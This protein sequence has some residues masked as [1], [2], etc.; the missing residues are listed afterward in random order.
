MGVQAVGLLEELG[1]PPGVAV[2]D[3]GSREG[4]EGE[5]LG[6]EVALVARLAEHGVEVLDG[7]L[8]YA[9]TA[10]FTVLITLAVTRAI[11]PRWMTYLGYASAAL[12]ATGVVIPLGVHAATLTN[13]AGY[14]A[15]CLWLIAM[16]VV[17]WRA[18]ADQG[19]LR[20]ARV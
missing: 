3:R 1:R 11:A 13:F 9:L 20:P 17:L 2:G 6:L 16:A 7:R 5:G 15:W 14:V 10:T 4:V 8:G 18:R 19:V 12:I